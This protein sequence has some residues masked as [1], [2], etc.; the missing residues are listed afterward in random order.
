MSLFV[1]DTD[2]VR[3]IEPVAQSINFEHLDPFMQEAEDKFVIPI[4]GQDF[5]ET[6]AENYGNE[7]QDKAL[8]LATRITVKMGLFFALPHL[9]VRLDNGGLVRDESEGT[10][11]AYGYQYRE[12]LLSLQTRGT[13]AIN[14]LFKYLEAKADDYPT[15]KANQAPKLRTQLLYSVDQFNE[16]YY[17]GEDYYLFTKLLPKIRAIENGLIKEILGADAYNELVTLVKTATPSADLDPVI[18]LCRAVIAPEAVYRGIRENVMY[19]PNGTIL[20]SYEMKQSGGSGN[21]ESNPEDA[22]L[23]TIAD[24]AQAMS[25]RAQKQLRTKI[26]ALVSEDKFDA[27]KNSSAYK[28]DLPN[29]FQN[30]TT[31]KYFYGG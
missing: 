28:V 11:T 9:S 22:M 16:H 8:L 7:D 29:H 12:L 25:D 14:A 4:L 15:W 13:E 18:D 24:R 1:R 2:K 21:I 19:T 23:L 27:H 20:K 3:A 30:K 5:A 6:L 26:N 10:K 31:R 17:I